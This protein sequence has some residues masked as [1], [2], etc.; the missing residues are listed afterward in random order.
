MPP[1]P[2]AALTA[3]GKPISLLGD[4]HRVG[5]RRD[6]LGGPWHD[7]HARRL[8]QLAGAGLRAHRLDRARG[9]ADEDDAGVLAGLRERR[10]LGQEAVAGV[11]RLGA[12]AAGDIEDLLDVQ[13][14]LG[15][16][17]LAEVV[18]LVGARD[19][20][21]VAV[22]LGVDGDARDAELLERAHDAD[23]DLAAV[24]DQDLA[25]HRPRKLSGQGP[26]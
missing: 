5:D 25:E 24:G 4:L 14:V 1:P 9:R 13:V 6:R 15:G 12:G 3:T 17:A 18:G 7:R 10:V 8:H 2:P 21:R 11:D 22:E 23:G 19:V 16:R 20:G 26:V